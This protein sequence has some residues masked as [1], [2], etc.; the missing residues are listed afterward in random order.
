MVKIHPQSNGPNLP[1]PPPP[2]R[3]NF[4]CFLFQ[5]CFF[6]VAAS[7]SLLLIIVVVLSILFGTRREDRH[8]LR[9]RQ[10]LRLLRYDAVRACAYY[11]TTPFAVVN[12]ASFYQGHKTTKALRV[13]FKGNKTVSFDD[14]DG[15]FL[16]SCYDEEKSGGGVYSVTVVLN[17]SVRT[18]YGKMKYGENHNYI[19]C[20]LRVP[21]SSTEETKFFYPSFQ[22]TPCAVVHI[23]T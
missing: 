2:Q 9:R 22:V 21:L 13:D 17:V 12:L 18:K 11:A 4:C 23:I 7:F 10:S 6:L 15:V 1:P 8:L 14:W 5:L 16:S 20:Y 3:N 19:Y